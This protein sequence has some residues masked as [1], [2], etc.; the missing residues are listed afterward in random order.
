M[1]AHRDGRLW[2][3]AVI[4]GPE[5][6]NGCEAGA[7]TVAGK[8]PAWRNPR[9]AGQ[10]VILALAQDHNLPTPPPRPL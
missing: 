4:V 8:R 7:G 10:L 3:K 1:R 9:S 6:I 5:L 2:R